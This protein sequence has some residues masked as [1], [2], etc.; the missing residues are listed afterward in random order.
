MVVDWALRWGGGFVSVRSSSVPVL[1]ALILY[2]ITNTPWV[3]VGAY[4]LGY[5]E[6]CAHSERDCQLKA[7]HT[8]W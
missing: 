6:L 3:G 2:S 5:N 1:V 7:P 4:I 8:R